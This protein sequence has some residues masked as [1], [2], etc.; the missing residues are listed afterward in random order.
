M[1]ELPGHRGLSISPTWRPEVHA[2]A[3]TLLSEPFQMK[4]QAACPHDVLLV[5]AEIGMVVLAVRSPWA[6]IACCDV[7]ERGEPS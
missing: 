7:A 6:L 3:R 2:V 1:T 5:V 4:F